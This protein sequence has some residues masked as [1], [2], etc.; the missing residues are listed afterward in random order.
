MAINVAVVRLEIKD[1]G[2]KRGR[3]D[4]MYTD[5]RALPILLLLLLLFHN[6]RLYSVAHIYIYVNEFR[7]ICVSRFINIY[8]NVGNAIMS[9]IMKRREH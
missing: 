5:R 6:V 1:E 2:E 4:N 8:M 7:H 9:C 3:G